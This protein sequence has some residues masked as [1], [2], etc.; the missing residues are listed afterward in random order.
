MAI[1]H[2]KTRSDQLTMRGA[3]TIHACPG[4]DL[5]NGAD[6]R[7]LP[8]DDHRVGGDIYPEVELNCVVGRLLLSPA[9]VKY[10]LDNIR[11]VTERSSNPKRYVGRRCRIEI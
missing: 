2:R 7:D 5:T 9:E 1:L 6:T 11:E 3:V 10:L 8:S 4:A